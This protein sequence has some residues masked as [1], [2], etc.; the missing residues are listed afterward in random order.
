MSPASRRS[1]PSMARPGPCTGSKRKA[2]LMPR[3]NRGA[4]ALTALLALASPSSHAQAVVCTNCA[5]ELTQLANNLQLI[6]QLARQVE[7][8]REAIR[9][10]ENLALNTEKLGSQDWGSALDEI[11]RK[12]VV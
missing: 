9:Q 8:V 12:S 6:D 5:T 11:D 3:R 10:S 4:L 2:W 1:M 7:L